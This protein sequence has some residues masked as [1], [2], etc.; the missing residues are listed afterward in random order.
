MTS[1]QNN[2]AELN[3][4]ERARVDACRALALSPS[5]CLA[6]LALGVVLKYWLIHAVEAATAPLPTLRKRLHARDGGQRSRARRELT[7]ALFQAASIDSDFLERLA[8]GADMDTPA[9]PSENGR[10]QRGWVSRVAQLA[11][12][13]LLGEAVSPELLVAPA[14][15]APNA[16]AALLAGRI[17]HAVVCGELVG[18]ANELFP[19][20]VD[21]RGVS[22]G[23]IHVI[24]VHGDW[25]QDTGAASRAILY[26]DVHD[27]FIESELTERLQLDSVQ[28]LYLGQAHEQERHQRLSEQLKGRLQLNPFQAARVAD[29]KWNTYELLRAAGVPTPQTMRV[30]AAMPAIEW[31]AEVTAFCH[32]CAIGG[33]VVQ[34]DCGTEGAGVGFFSCL[35]TGAP[36][37]E[38]I[39]HIERL[40]SVGDVVVRAPI[41]G[42]R[43]REGQASYSAD[44][45]VNVAFDGERYLAESGYLQVAGDPDA[46]ASSV[47]RGGRIVP[48]SGGALSGLGISNE[49]RGPILETACRAAEAFAKGG[50]RLGLL[51]VDLKVKKAESG[52]SAWVLDVNPRPA[53]LSY[54][55][56]FDSHEPGVSTGMWAGLLLSTVG[57]TKKPIGAKP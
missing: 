1:A 21:A 48:L 51:G 53:G 12:D 28:F 18:F 55:E 44:L 8:S 7:R 38:A 19:L 50:H 23:A 20:V 33:L 24:G 57:A 29:S 46:F 34:P 10:D 14:P 54:C 6:P 52:L 15:L 13:G 36:E 31:T 56:L 41:K 2:V 9:W 40:Q 22:D 35:A 47:G 45:R 39:E 26:D 30:T 4:F 32:E 16:V 49:Q 17:I 3:A 37:P 43:F 5:E 11:Y 42:L 27:V 25:L